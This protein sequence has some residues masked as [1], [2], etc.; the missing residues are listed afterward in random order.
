A[1]A[2]DT[3]G[4]AGHQGTVT[5]QVGYGGFDIVGG[6]LGRHGWE[7]YG[8]HPTAAMCRRHTEFADQWGPTPSS[9]D[10]RS[11]HSRSASRT[12]S[13]RAGSRLPWPSNVVIR[14][15][16]CATVFGWMCSL[17]LTA[18]ALPDSSIQQSRVAAS[19]VPRAWS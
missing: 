2:A 8:D 10:S 4:G 17:L 3:A 14:S 6:Y 11:R 18:V 12:S 19:S 9:N 15:R 7:G 1:R 16:R 13:T 5:G